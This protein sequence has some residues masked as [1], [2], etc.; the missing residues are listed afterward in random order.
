MS[1]M[2]K[3]AHPENKSRQVPRSITAS[4]TKRPLRAQNNLNETGKPLVSKGNITGFHG[5]RYPQ[6]KKQPLES[7]IYVYKRA[8]LDLVLVKSDLKNNIATS[9]SSENPISQYSPTNGR[10]GV[11]APNYDFSS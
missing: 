6:F 4:I 7:P 3:I 8:N 10:E 9:V 1:I 11:M 2:K 5:A